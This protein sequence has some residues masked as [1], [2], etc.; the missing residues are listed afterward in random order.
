MS[1]IKNT[2]FRL[3]HILMNNK[4]V[5]KIYS[6]FPWNDILFSIKRKIFIDKTMQK[7]GYIIKFKNS[8]IKFYL[9]YY[10]KDSIQKHIIQTRNFYELDFLNHICT[11][12]NG[13]VSKAIQDGLVLDIGANIGNHTIFFLTKKAKKVISFEPV[14]D[15]FDILKKN[16]E[17]NNFQNKVNLFNIGVG[18]TK[19]KAI[20]KYY[21]SKNIGMSQLSSDKNGDIP[22]L[23]L[24][25]L[26][27]EEHIN[28][29]KIDV[30]GFE[31]DV[32]KGMTETIK[33]NKPLIMI[34][35]RDYLFA[36]IEDILLSI[37]Y[38]RI[39]IDIDIYN[40]G[41]YLYYPQE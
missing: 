16:I 6:I 18:Q 9:P 20:L 27:I 40:I 39:T 37:G 35:I 32:I 22:I 17:I 28:F 3:R 4:I 29:I 31:A 26:N 21:N 13:I 38:N 25:E 12:K 15:T 36:E 7:H 11:I 8:N 19:G 23:S 34:E 41:N 5:V 33:R 24:D 10:N 30:E 2:I 14:K 1:L